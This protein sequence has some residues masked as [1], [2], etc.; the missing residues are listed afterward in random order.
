MAV[1]H[2]MFHAGYNLKTLAIQLWHLQKPAIYY[3]AVKADYIFGLYNSGPVHTTITIFRIIFK[4][5]PV[6]FFNIERL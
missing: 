5:L 6:N 3:I 2:A 1:L 4:I